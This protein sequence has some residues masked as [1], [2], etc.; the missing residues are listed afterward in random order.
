M[1]VGNVKRILR[2]VC[3]A[4]ARYH[5][6]FADGTF[7]V[8]GVKAAQNNIAC[9]GAVFVLN[10]DLAAAEVCSVDLRRILRLFISEVGVIAC[11]GVEKGA[12]HS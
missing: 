6:R 11:C 2:A 1:Q 10:V 12:D 4:A 8:R 5:A 9:V 3:G 7:R